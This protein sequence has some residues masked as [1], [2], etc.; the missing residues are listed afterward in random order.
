MSNTI[1]LVK[2]DARGAKRR[3]QLSLEGTTVVTAAGPD[4]KPLKSVSKPFA[5]ESTA[6]RAYDKALRAKLRDGFA[7][8]RDPATAGVG[9]VVLRAFASSAGAGFLLD[10]S[11]DGR[12]AA[13]VGSATGLSSY[14]VELVDVATGARRTVLERS[15]APRQGFVHAVLF[16]ASAAA[17]Y[18]AENETTLRLDLAT[19]AV[20]PVA[21]YREDAATRFNPFVVRPHFD[22]A[23]ERL[24]VFDAG[25][26]VR[27]LDAAG[28]AVFELDVGSPTTECRAAGISPSGKLLALYRVSRGR[29]YGHADAMHDD[30]NLVEVWDVDAGTLRTTIAL[31]DKLSAVGVDPADGSLLVTRE[32]AQGPVAYDLATGAEQW[33]FDDP[34]RTDRLAE[35]HAWEFSPDGSLLAVG[36]A[37]TAL[38]DA[39]TRTE[40]PLAEPGGYQ[41]PRVRFSADGALLA[42][43]EHGACVVRRVR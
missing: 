14:W 33:R 32:Y 5:D 21:G 19:G 34:W 1:E 8:V 23:R 6:A 29:V 4:G 38:Y 12:F 28:A 24:V 27:V 35:A 17:L 18:L 20:T 11:P 26:R 40:I 22:R 15:A 31:A 30:T 39:A 43:A 10:L 3:C 25:D 16:D 2:V 36:R 41:V 13:T 42:S 37:S 9:D 7:F